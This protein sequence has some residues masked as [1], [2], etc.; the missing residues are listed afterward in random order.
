[1]RSMISA[2]VPGVDGFNSLSNV[3]IRTKLDGTLE[4]NTEDF[5]RAI[6]DNFAQVAAVFQRQQVRLTARYLLRWVVLVQEL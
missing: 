4:I 2:S 6:N 3:G 5:D 1:M